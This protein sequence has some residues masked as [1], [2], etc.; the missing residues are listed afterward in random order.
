MKFERDYNYEKRS[1]RVVCFYLGFVIISSF[2]AI[3][4]LLLGY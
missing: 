1:W 2:V 4:A 3:V